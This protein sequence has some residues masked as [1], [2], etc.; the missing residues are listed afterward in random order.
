MSQEG[1]VLF[2]AGDEDAG[3][4]DLSALADDRGY[5]VVQDLIAAAEMGGGHVESF[6]DAPAQKGDQDT[7]KIAYATSFVGRG[8]GNT[9]ILIGGFF[10]NVS[11]IE[12]PG[13]DDSLIPHPEVTA[14]DVT[15]RESL[16][17]FVR[18]AV[19]GYVTALREHGT[20]RYS[21]ILN[22][23][24][25]EGGDWRHEHIYL[26]IYNTNG[27]VVFHGA[28][29]SLEARNQ[30]DLEDVNGVRFVQLL[31][32]AA[33]AG[34]GFVEYHYDDPV[35]TGDEDIGSPKLSYAES[36]VARLFSAPGSTSICPTTYRKSPCRSILSR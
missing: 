16:K 12:P 28:D 10:Q 36:F 17:A 6:W 31:I 24:R 19:G 9:I 33:Q 34:G 7:A 14:A 4:K 26:F 5:A 18:G 29:R 20:G 23:F 11:G 21:E 35:L 25:A 3:G 2:H 30:L 27:D 13:H 15:D 1:T 8:Y 32:E 22:A